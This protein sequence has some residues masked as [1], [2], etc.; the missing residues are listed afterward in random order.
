MNFFSVVY[1]LS[2][3]KRALF[4]T[5]IAFTVSMSKQV[6]NG[7][8]CQASREQNIFSCSTKLSSKYILLIK[9]ISSAFLCYELWRFHEHVNVLHPLARL[10]WRDV[11][12]NVKETK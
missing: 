8:S 11:H 10:V 1:F 7:S 3:K 4:C 12:K 9:L 6:L 5:S 2:T